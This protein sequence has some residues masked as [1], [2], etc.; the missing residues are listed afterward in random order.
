MNFFQNPFDYQS[1]N[2]NVFFFIQI[3]FTCKI[4]S[5]QPAQ[6]LNRSSILLER[7][8][9]CKGNSVL[10]SNDLKTMVPKFEKS[11]SLKIQLPRGKNPCHATQS[12]K[13]QRRLSLQFYCNFHLW[14]DSS[15]SDY[16]LRYNVKSFSEDYPL[17]SLQDQLRTRFS[18]RQS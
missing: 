15:E 2:N 14:Q 13:L 16:V 8:K 12:K 11:G 7:K 3:C 4:H 9:M 18:S 6:H 5:S 1:I 10:L 17:L